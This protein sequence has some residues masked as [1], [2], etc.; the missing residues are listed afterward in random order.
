MRDMIR[1]ITER[2]MTEEEK[3]AHR[4]EIAAEARARKAYVEVVDALRQ[5]FALERKERRAQKREER[6]EC[7]QRRALLWGIVKNQRRCAV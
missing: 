5:C 6:E 7:E 1:K 4:A 2:G 3:A